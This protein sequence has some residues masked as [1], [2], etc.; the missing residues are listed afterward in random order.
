MINATYTPSAADVTFGSVT[1]TLTVS[2]YQ[3][4]G[5]VSDQVK[6]ILTPKAE[7]YAGKNI[8]ICS[9][10]P[11]VIADATVTGSNTVS[12]THDGQGT[13]GNANTIHPTYI[14]AAGESGNVHLYL[15][16]V[17]TMPC[18]NAS[19][20]LTLQIIP[21]AFVNLGE[22]ISSCSAV[23]VV[24]NST[25][26]SNYTS[27]NWTTSGTGTFSNATILNPIYTP[28]L[29]DVANGYTELTLRA[30]GVLPCGSSTEVIR[31]NF[32][33]GPV[34]N[35]GVDKTLCVNGP[36]T[37]TDATAINYTS[38]IWS[39]NG[40][41]VLSN[42]NTLNPTYIPAPGETGNIEFK[43]TAYGTSSCSTVGI[44]DL[45][46]LVI[47][48]P[49]SV[50][51]GP[52]QEIFPGSTTLLDGSVS[53]GT[54]VYT[55][56]WSPEQ[57]LINN[58]ILDPTT[59]SLQ[60]VTLFTLTVLDM[61]SLCTQSDDVRIGMNGVRRPE[62]IDDFDTTGLNAAALVKVL[63][64]DKDPVGLGLTVTYVGNPQ[65]GIVSLNG[66][67]TILY[68]PE[69][70]FVGNDTFIYIICDKGSPSKC[71][72]A[73][74]TITIFPIRE[75]IEVYNLVTPN[76]DGKNDYWHIRGIDEYP[77]NEIIIF[78]RWGDKLR[79]FKGYN[80]TSNNWDGTNEKQ[81]PLPD[82]VYFYVIKIKDMDL[83]KN[84]GWVYIR[85]SRDN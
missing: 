25:Q 14:P 61:N 30:E 55:Y 50:N 59:Y 54:G 20:S 6:V 38:I 68:T 70:N 71:D 10:S 79:E 47:Y 76:G 29:A 18:G 24:L 16:A 49:L 53:G 41:G 56:N 31:I 39:H 19:D 33:A 60:T 28:S 84:T 2:G 77:D 45:V 12:W 4:C 51:A 17:G 43:L 7:V 27:L 69:Y 73:L 81:E 48:T 85:S 37:F 67:G 11:Y 74:V 8:T 72:T 9:N 26:A 13:L 21:A 52:D 34:V 80:N 36:I 58:T 75:Y 5:T 78:N 32:I 82:G 66:D 23:P 64:N 83:E 42:Q 40:L 65:H 62:A 35:A 3:P 15:T 22:D 44:F 57:L 46:T 63:D 1:L